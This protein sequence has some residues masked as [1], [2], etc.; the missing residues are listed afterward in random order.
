M[1]AVN[2]KL[3]HSCTPTYVGVLQSSGCRN[4]CSGCP[5]TV[6][7]QTICPQV[8]PQPVCHPVCPDGCGSATYLSQSSI[9]QVSNVVAIN[10]KPVTGQS[11]ATAK[12]ASQSIVKVAASTPGNF[13]PEFR[14]WHSATG[15]KSNSLLKLVGIKDLNA[16]FWCEDAQLTSVALKNLSQ[17]DL[18]YVAHWQKQVPTSLRSFTDNT[19]RYSTKM[20]PVEARGDYLFA[21]RENGTL[22]RVKL[23]RLSAV[24]QLHIAQWRSRTPGK[25]VSK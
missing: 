21:I 2:H 11:L 8:C 7:P 14:E 25:L 3:F 5:Q 12:P 24:D 16:I 20:L 9:L 10:G 6:C 4:S 22:A 19:G 15:K 13:L 17:E 1:F 18:K 23:D